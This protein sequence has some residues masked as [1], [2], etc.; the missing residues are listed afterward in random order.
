MDINAKIVLSFS[1]MLVI[2]LTY[3]SSLLWTERRLRNIIRLIDL[4]HLTVDANKM[5][6][7]D[8]NE[9]V[10]DGQLTMVHTV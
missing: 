2:N 1:C 5:N 10:R 9:A 8:E 6:L 7:T 4:S 3:S